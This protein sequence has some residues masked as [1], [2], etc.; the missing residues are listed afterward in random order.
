M[1]LLRCAPS[2]SP[3]SPCTPRCSCGPGDRR[4]PGRHGR[5]S[6][7][8]SVRD[9]ARAPAPAAALLAAAALPFIAR[10][11]AFLAF[12]VVQRA[13]GGPGADLLPLLFDRDFV[14]GSPSDVAWLFTFLARRRPGFVFLETGLNGLI[15]VGLLWG[16]PVP[17]DP[18]PAPVALRPLAR[19]VRLRRDRRPAARPFS[20]EQG[21]GTSGI[22]LSATPRAR[23]DL[24]RTGSP[25]ASFAIAALP[26]LLVFLFFILAATGRAARRP[27]AVSRNPR[28]CGS[29]SP[30]SCG[31]RARSARPTTR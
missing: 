29:T 26:L 15:L 11:V 28:C 4:L 19:R 21:R 3:G 14:P 18:L 23:A 7:A 22:P 8:R 9:G 30:S 16:R 6:R 31:S 25:L 17:A 27:A 1:M 10:G 5:G 2:P 24:R 12:G 20:R 13:T